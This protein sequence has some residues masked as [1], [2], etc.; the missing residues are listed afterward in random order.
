MILVQDKLVPTTLDFLLV[1]RTQR[2]PPRQALARRTAARVLAVQAQPTVALIHLWF[3]NRAVE[4]L[5][6]PHHPESL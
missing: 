2:D 4:A 3:L 6:P 1:V 5:P